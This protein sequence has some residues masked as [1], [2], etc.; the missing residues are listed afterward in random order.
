MTRL[1]TLL[2]VDDEP[3]VLLLLRSCFAGPEYAVSTAANGAEG[4]DAF[5]SDHPDLVLTDLRMPVMDGFELIERIRES[6]RAVPIMVVSSLNE[7]M[8]KVRALK[9]G[10]D[11]YM[12]KPLVLSELKARVAA[13]LRR[14]RLREG[15]VPC[16]GG[17]GEGA[18]G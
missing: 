8:D 13:L 16:P 4:L 2:V 14:R 11:D 1:P 6:S 7:T 17:P 15:G 18:G 5:L 9:L 3:A 10:A 12:T